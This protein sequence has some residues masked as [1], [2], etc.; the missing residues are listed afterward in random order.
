MKVEPRCD[1][2]LWMS[3]FDLLTKNQKEFLFIFQGY[4]HYN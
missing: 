1:V 2:L 4:L 3:L